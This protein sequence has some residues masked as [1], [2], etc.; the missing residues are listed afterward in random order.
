MTRER[1][2]GDT[3]YV[4]EAAHEGETEGNEVVG[5]FIVRRKSYSIFFWIGVVISHTDIK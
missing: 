5:K 1:L 4:Q 2:V 3:K